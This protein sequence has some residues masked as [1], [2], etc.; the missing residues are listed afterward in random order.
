MGASFL[1]AS[2]WEKEEYLYNRTMVDY[3]DS[4]KKDAAI[5]AKAK[6]MADTT[7]K[8][9]ET[10]ETE[11][12]VLIIIQAVTLALN[13]VLTSDLNTHNAFIFFRRRCKK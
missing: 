11:P 9:S 1:K 4:K 12:F 10:K 6:L 5:A 2:W 7:N 13:S 3:K 8:T